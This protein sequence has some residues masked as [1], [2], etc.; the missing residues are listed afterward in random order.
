VNK[1]FQREVL[2]SQQAVLRYCKTTI[3]SYSFIIIV[4]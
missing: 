4:V 2:L 3:A 1:H